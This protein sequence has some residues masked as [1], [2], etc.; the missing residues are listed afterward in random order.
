MKID[1]ELKQIA[2]NWYKKITKARSYNELLKATKIK[3]QVLDLSE[4]SSCVIGESHGFSGMYSTSDQKRGEPIQNGCPD[5]T[6]FSLE[7]YI[8]N[9][10]KGRVKQFKN[11]VH[12][13]LLHINMKHGIGINEY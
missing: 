10:K 12:N 2:P 13:Y 4:Y 9:P 5:C 7:I 3:D 6:K 1:K 11:A 8:K